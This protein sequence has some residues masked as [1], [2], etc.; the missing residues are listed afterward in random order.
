MNRQVKAFHR[1]NI[2]GLLQKT[3]NLTLLDLEQRE[4]IPRGAVIDWTHLRTFTQAI[5]ILFER[6]I[7]S[8]AER[9]AER[10]II[11]ELRGRINPIIPGLFSLNN[12]E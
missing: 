10:N 12:Y 9:V 8:E 4:L 6:E 7:G 5:D 3:I 11:I 2:R 1:D